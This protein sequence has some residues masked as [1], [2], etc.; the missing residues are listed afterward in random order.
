[1]TLAIFPAR[2]LK[3]TLV[4]T[5]IL[6]MEVWSFVRFV[7][8]S[9]GEVKSFYTCDRCLLVFFSVTNLPP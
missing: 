3:E 2:Y 1:M 7:F 8:M 9:R 6:G 4:H 5:K